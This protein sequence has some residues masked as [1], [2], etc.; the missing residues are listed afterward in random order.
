[1]NFNL[2]PMPSRLTVTNPN[3]VV[4]QTDLFLS[5]DLKQYVKKAN[6]LICETG[7]IKVDYN[8]CE[9]LETEEYRLKISAE[10][11]QITVSAPIGA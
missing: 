6:E 4:K 5:D 1:M 11:I 10:G 2:I 3:M 8:I 9:S 7:T